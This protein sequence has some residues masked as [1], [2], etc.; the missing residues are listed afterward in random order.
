IPF[1]PNDPPRWPEVVEAVRNIV[2][3]WALNARKFER[4]GEFIER[5]GWPR[6]FELTGI[7]FTREHIDDYKYA[8]LTFKRSAQLRH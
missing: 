8:G 2:E 6:F 4:M 3:I 1:L 7:E 5:I